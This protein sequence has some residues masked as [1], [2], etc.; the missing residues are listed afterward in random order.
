MLVNEAMQR[1][2]RNQTAAAKLLG[3][4]QPALNKRLKKT[5]LED[6]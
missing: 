4:T 1:S 6:Q 2:G 3:I 5:A